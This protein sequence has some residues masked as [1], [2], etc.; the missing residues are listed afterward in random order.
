[1]KPHFSIC[2]RLDAPASLQII[3]TKCPFDQNMQIQKKPFKRW[4]GRIWRCCN[5][6]Y[7]T[8]G[9]RW[10]ISLA[11][12]FVPLANQQKFVALFPG[13][14]LHQILMVGRAGIYIIPFQAI[15]TPQD[16]F[17]EKWQ[18]L[19]QFQ[20]YE[21]YWDFGFRQFQGTQT[22]SQSRSPQNEVSWKNPPTNTLEKVNYDWEQ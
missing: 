11:R 16:H 22:L 4:A 1:M 2:G 5:W 3:T 6:T 15:W 10:L 9:W 17:F 13:R 8:G 19:K 20:N 18:R 7:W 21:H 14:K 12:S